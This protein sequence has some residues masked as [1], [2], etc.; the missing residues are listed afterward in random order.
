ML[1][2]RG[3]AFF[4]QE[5]L[6]QTETAISMQTGG[7]D[8]HIAKF[9]LMRMELEAEVKE[10]EAQLQA[11]KDALREVRAVVANRRGDP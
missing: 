6:A 10:L 5:E 11:K 2:I 8:D 9:A 1:R 7:E 4:S 3:R